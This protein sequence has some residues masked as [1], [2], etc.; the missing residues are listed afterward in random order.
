MTVEIRRG[1]TRFMDRGPGRAT[2][3]SLSFGQHYDPERLRIGPM[4]CHDEHLLGDG[5]GFE[6]HQHDEL[7]IV[8]WVVSGAVTHVD[9]LGSEVTLSAG[10]V[11]HLRAGSGVTHSEVAAAPQTRFVQVWITPDEPDLEPAYSAPDVSLESG[12]LVEV[13]RPTSTAVFS[14]ARLAA[15]ESV[16]V[17]AGPIRHVY[18]AAGALLR[19]SLAEPLTQGDA[20]VVSDEADATHDLTVTAAIETELLV[21]RLG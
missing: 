11:G 16:T 21:W 18:V 3:H 13:L 17:P 7:E 5:K 4:V 10:Q 19:S 15:G 12:R 2:W 20:F 9:S 14:V 1:T 6:T 8:S